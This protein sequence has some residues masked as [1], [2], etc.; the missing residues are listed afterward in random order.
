[1]KVYGHRGSAATHPENSVAGVAAAFA[2]GADGVE[3]DVRRTADGLLVLCH[4][5]AFAGGPPIVTLTA[6]SLPPSAAAVAEALDAARGRVVLEVKNLPGEPD[7][8]APNE[9]TVRLLVALL[10]GRSGDDVVVS[11]FDWYA[12]EAARDAGLR[13]A[14]LSPPGVALAAALA[15][16]S[17]AGH[18]EVHPHWTAALDA[19]EAVAAARA[20]GRAVVCWT[21]DDVAVARR[22]RDLGVDGV[23]T[24]DPAA[25][26]AELRA[27]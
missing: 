14:F 5:A 26:V 21:V 20:G 1:V 8:D 12:A 10:A 18:A 9:S 27:G 16:V 13:S 15:Y 3:V 6:D 11:S 17:D 23:I 19:P 24:N 7:F 22:L 2:A 25:M 4:D